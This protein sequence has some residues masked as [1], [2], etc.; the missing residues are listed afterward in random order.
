MGMGVAL[1]VLTMILTFLK[2]TYSNSY[3][4]ALNYFK[5][6]ISFHVE[7]KMMSFKQVY[8]LLYLFRPFI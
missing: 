1:G 2:S 5:T 6:F 4:Y 3:V 7:I 8:N